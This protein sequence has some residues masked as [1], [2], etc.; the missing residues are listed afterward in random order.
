MGLDG[1]ISLYDVY[2]TG[3]FSA[4]RKPSFR[5]E[6]HPQV[7]KM[8]LPWIGVIT[9]HQLQRYPTYTVNLT[10]HNYEDGG[11]FAPTDLAMWAGT[12]GF[13]GVASADANMI[14]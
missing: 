11:S 14:S 13:S 5:S 12:S 3:Q 9:P 6:S 8:H 10:Q 1:P 7:S 4:L 2:S